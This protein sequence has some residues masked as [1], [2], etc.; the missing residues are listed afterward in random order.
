[1]LRI[2][3]RVG[4][5]EVE[6]ESNSSLGEDVMDRLQSILI[7]L[8]KQNDECSRLSG[9]DK[10][11]PERKR[12]PSIITQEKN[13]RHVKRT[14]KK[15]TFAVVKNLNLRPEGKDSLADFYSKKHPSSAMDKTT[16]FVYYLSEV[17]EEK[18][19]TIDHIYTCYKSMK[20]PV[21]GNLRQ[22]IIDTAS[23]KGTIDTSDTSNIMLTTTGENYVLYDLEGKGE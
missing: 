13:I 9:N 6:V 20:L 21:P 22:N 19:I 3:A 4:E 5:A 8:K 1:M 17:L 10:S 14:R 11:E 18:S 15:E 7:S 2:K 12:I 23:R 16:I